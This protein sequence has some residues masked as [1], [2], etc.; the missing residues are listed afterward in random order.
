M[1]GAARD[2]TLSENCVPAGRDLFIYFFFKSDDSVL[3]RYSVIKN[4][5]CTLLIVYILKIDLSLSRINVPMILY[6]RD[7]AK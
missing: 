2:T 3:E 5:Q 6:W 1:V 7:I 4:V